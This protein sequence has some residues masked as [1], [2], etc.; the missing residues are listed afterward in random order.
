MDNGFTGEGRELNTDDNRPVFT[1][2]SSG[3]RLATSLFLKFIVARSLAGLIRP[4][5]ESSDRRVRNT[6]ETLL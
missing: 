4:E 1:G 6:V 3:T 2:Y 5:M